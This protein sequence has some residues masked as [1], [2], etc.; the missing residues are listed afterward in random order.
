L[1]I[2]QRHIRIPFVQKSRGQK[3]PN[4][5]QTN[6][7]ATGDWIQAQRI[8]KNLTLGHLAGKMGIA[9]ALVRAWESGA[10]EPDKRQ[11]EILTGIFG[12]TP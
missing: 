6:P 7:L 3:S 10:T 4:P 11:L 12:M 8:G 5:L 2:A 9:T 1:G